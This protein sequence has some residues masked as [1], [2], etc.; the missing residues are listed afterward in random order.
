[1]VDELRLIVFPVVVGQGKRLFGT[2]TM[3]STWRLTASRSTSTGALIA[4][5]RR[6]GAIATGEFTV[7]DE[8]QIVSV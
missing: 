7:E 5:Y 4:V 6:A 1:M 3:P 2:G 8:Q